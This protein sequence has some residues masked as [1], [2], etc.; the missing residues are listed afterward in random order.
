MTN[1]WR[2]APWLLRLFLLPPALI[3]TVISI[4]FLADPAGA[5][6]ASGITFDSS[7][8]LTNLR[9][10]IGGLFLTAACV[11]WFCL[12]S[13]R[14]LLAGLGFVATTMGVVLAVRLVSV[15]IDGTV[16]ASLPVLLAETVFLLLSLTGIFIEFR[17]RQLENPSN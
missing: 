10:G 14:R 17:R 16:R 13:K 12:F 9:S 2:L 11:T 1:K 7:V 5:A 6:G 8:G 15:V 3:F 4:R